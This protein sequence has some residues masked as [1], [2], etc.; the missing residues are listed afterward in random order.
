MRRFAAARLINDIIV[1]WSHVH[2]YAH[3]KLEGQLSMI[4]KP[5][6]KEML[7]TAG[8]RL[9]QLLRAEGAAKR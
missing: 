7:R 1:G 8:V 2:G 6:Q 3:L 5:V 4:P 9:A